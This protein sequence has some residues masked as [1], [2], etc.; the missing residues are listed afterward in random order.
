MVFRLEDSVRQAQNLEP[1]EASSRYKSWTTKASALVWASEAPKR[2]FCGSVLRSSTDEEAS[3]ILSIFFNGLP[4]LS[5]K[6]LISGKSYAKCSLRV[7]FHHNLG[8]INYISPIHL[9]PRVG[10]HFYNFGPTD[11]IM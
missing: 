8:E 1:P 2:D 9:L 4:F 7:A 5:D 11:N 10:N 3:G 6:T